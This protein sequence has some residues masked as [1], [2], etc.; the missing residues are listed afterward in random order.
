MAKK[1]KKEV[2]FLFPSC[3]LRIFRWI[4][5]YESI[6]C[7]DTRVLASGERTRAFARK[8]TFHTYR[9]NRKDW[10]RMSCNEGNHCFQLRRCAESER[11]A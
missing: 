2:W 10:R 6:G 8:T 7:C 1:A 5:P 11:N 4:W 9:R 3:K